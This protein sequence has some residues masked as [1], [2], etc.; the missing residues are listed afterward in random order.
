MEH[1]WRIADDLILRPDVSVVCREVDTDFLQIAPDL[2][3]E[4]FSPSTHLKD[5]SNK[6]TE[7]ARYGVG[8]YVMVDPAIG[9]VKALQLDGEEYR[10]L[11]PDDTGKF[12]LPL[13]DRCVVKLPARVDAG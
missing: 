3:V 5:R 2:A 8:I 7:Y 9:E 11:E 1:D 6:R 13:R 12:S 4:V 10:E